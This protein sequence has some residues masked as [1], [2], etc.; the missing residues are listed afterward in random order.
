[1]DALQG[2]RQ[3]ILLMSEW[4]ALFKQFWKDL[5]NAV[6]TASFGKF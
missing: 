4:S 1:M 2:Q 5:S 3:S 6:P